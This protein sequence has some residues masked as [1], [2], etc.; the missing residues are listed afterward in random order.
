MVSRKATCVK[1]AKTCLA[2]AF[3]L[4]AAT[5]AEAARYWTG[6]TS[7]K[8]SES[9][10]WSGSTG[11]RYFFNNQLTGEKRDYAYL[12]GDVTESIGVCFGNVPSSGWW[13][14]QGQ[15]QY[16]YNNSGGSAYDNGLICIG[17]SGQSSSVRFHAITITTKNLTVGG[18]PSASKNY[19][20]GDMT[21]YLVLDELNNEATAY[22]GPISITAT[23]TCD[24]YKGE[25]YATNAT[26]ACSG[27]M[28]LC[29]FVLDMTGG[30]WSVAGDF[31][32]GMSSGTATVTQRSGTFSVASGKWTRLENGSTST[33]NLY[34]GTFKTRRITNQNAASAS[35]ILDGGIIEVNGNAS[36]YGLIDTTVDVRVGTNG[37]TINTG[38][39]TF[40]VPAA[41]NAV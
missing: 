25:L 37:G 6:N 36:T 3:A 10:N 4:G 33:L 26:V 30:D 9:K 38:G 15:G 23:S 19:L 40:H 2:A 12:A 21:G 31:K 41:I 39:N 24:F 28:Q 32:I 5:T 34:G 27:N 7:S 29:N 20:Q 14:F 22:E 16:S 18:D 1:F 17:Y 11:R 13:R 8:W 35:V